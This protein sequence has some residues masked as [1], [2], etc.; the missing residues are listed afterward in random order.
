MKKYLV[1][2]IS[3]LILVS[4]GSTQLSFEY[5]IEKYDRETLTLNL[6]DQGLQEM[7]DFEKYMT[8]S[9]LQDIYTIDLSDNDIQRIPEGTF[10]IFPN[11]KAI[12]LSSNDFKFG[13]DVSI[14]KTI[15]TLSL[16]NNILDAIAWFNAYTEL[17]R[18]DL[19]DN[20]LEDNNLSEFGW[21]KKLVELRVEGNNIS[22]ELLESINKINNAPARKVIQ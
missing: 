5:F 16:S 12:D 19:T 20:N 7:P 3:L 6:S 1:W 22:E 21:F 18:V 15:K 10:D 2:L 8:G 14:P 9:W 4:C 13:S 11:L 17:S